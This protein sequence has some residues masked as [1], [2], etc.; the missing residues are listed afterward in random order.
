MQTCVV[1]N[2]RT[3]L[4]YP[5]N[6]PENGPAELLCPGEHSQLSITEIMGRLTD[7]RDRWL[8]LT[9]EE[10]NRTEKCEY[11]RGRPGL[12]PC[13]E[14]NDELEQPAGPVV[15]ILLD[16]GHLSTTVSFAY[17]SDRAIDGLWLKEDL[18]YG[19]EPEQSPATITG[20]WLERVVE[21]H[22]VAND[23]EGARKRWRTAENVSQRFF[24][25][26]TYGL[27]GYQLRRLIE[28]PEIEEWHQRGQDVP[29][30]ACGR[31]GCSGRCAI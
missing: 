22:V 13:P 30:M 12:F 1:C 25:A 19:D 24:A 23:L 11:C 2:M 18:D 3:R 28:I 9:D 29:C 27:I 15:P 6:D 10:R 21:A 4:R 14:C 5:G 26:K 31:N 8:A 16:Y 20:E 17:V 7:L